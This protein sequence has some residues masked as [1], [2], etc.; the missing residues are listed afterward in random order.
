MI[1]YRKYL[2]SNQNILD[3]ESDDIFFINLS[4]LI[5]L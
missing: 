1:N 2:K 5:Q 4:I 3:V